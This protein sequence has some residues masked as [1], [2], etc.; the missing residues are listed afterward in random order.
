M[1]AGVSPWI[2]LEAAEYHQLSDWVTFALCAETDP[3][4][5]FP[6]HGE[7]NARAKGVCRLC[8]VRPQ[9]L[10]HALTSP[11]APYGIWGGTTEY[12]RR[13]M[14]QGRGMPIGRYMPES[15][16]GS[17]AGAKRHYRAHEVPCAPC[18]RAAAVAKADRRRA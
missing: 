8:S 15:A 12:E 6:S 14:R 10:E 9:C 3:E 13:E 5:F 16:C 7:S 18:R 11:V 1:S 4:L 17:A 2:L